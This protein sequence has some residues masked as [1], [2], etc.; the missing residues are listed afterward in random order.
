MTSFR[1]GD[2]D[3]RQ[4]G[5]DL[6]AKQYFIVKTDALGQ[7]ILAT[8][9]TDNIRGV[10]A[11]APKATET[12]DVANLNGSGTFKVLA[13]GTIA[14]DALLT[15][16]ASGKAV[17]AV[18]STAGAQPS[19]RVFGRARAAAAAGDVLEYDKLSLLY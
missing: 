5:A 16:D 2:Y 6:T 13:G 1:Q 11:N 17:T 19:V 14:K 9:P 3:S 7:Y 8:G 18:Q 10:L 12:A 15:S 4:A